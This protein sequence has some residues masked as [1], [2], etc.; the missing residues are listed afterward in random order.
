MKNL[1]DVFKLHALGKKSVWK[2]WDMD[3]DELTSS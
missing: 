1:G 2:L 3:Y